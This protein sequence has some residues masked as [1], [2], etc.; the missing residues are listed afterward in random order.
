MR[1]LIENFVYVIPGIYFGTGFVIVNELHRR[2][3]GWWKRGKDRPN[4]SESLKKIEN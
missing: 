4:S 1:A 2:Y 3:G